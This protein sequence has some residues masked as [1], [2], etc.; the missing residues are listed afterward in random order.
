MTNKQQLSK[1]NKQGTSMHAQYFHTSIPTR[2]YTAKQPHHPPIPK[3]KLI[4]AV[5]WRYHFNDTSQSYR[6]TLKKKKNKFAASLEFFAPGTNFDHFIKISSIEKIIFCKLALVG[7]F[8][9]RRPNLGR[10]KRKKTKI[11]LGAIK[12][13]SHER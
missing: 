6:V 5:P 8:R 2:Q 1:L 13:R 3:R 10:Q 12:F 11:K 7:S 4:T 9:C